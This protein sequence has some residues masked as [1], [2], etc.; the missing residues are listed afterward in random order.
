MLELAVQFSYGWPLKLQVN[1][2]LQLK[3]SKG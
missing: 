2:I 1:Q 3:S